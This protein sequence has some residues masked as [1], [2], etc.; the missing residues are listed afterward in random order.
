[1]E[2]NKKNMTEQFFYL[3]GLLLF[4]LV[5]FDLGLFNVALATE[6]PNNNGYYSKFHVTDK[7][8]QKTQQLLL[9]KTN[10]PFSLI[11]MAGCAWKMLI[12]PRQN[13]TRDPPP[14]SRALI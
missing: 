7:Y 9:L 10:A 13:N 11:Q 2:A 6:T 3:H 8:L 5:F 4:L 12:P 1:L 14:P